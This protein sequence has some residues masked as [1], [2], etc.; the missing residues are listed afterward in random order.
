MA[1]GLSASG[2]DSPAQAMA[3]ASPRPGRLVRLSDGR[4]LNFRC[5]G[6]GGPTVILEAGFAASSRE[7]T[8]VQAL[9][10]RHRRVCA[11][12][13]AG[14]GLSD[15]GP[16]PR[17]GTAIARD[18]DQGL[19]A[20]G[21]NGPFILVGHSAGG[22]YVRVFAALRPAE[23][24]G[25]VLADPSVEHQD[26]RFSSVFGANAASLAPLRQRAERCL[27]AAEAH[28]LPSPDPALA[29]CAPTPKPGAPSAAG[30][31]QLAEALRPSTWQT[32]IS[33]LDNLW[34]PTSEEVATGLPNYG[35]I[36]IIVLTADGTYAIAPEWARDTLLTYWRALHREIA[37][38]S[39]RGEERLVSDSSHMM[40][41][42]RA[43]AIA[44]AIDEVAATPAEARPV[45]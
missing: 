31:E 10:A 45:Q 24:R 8:K 32:Q 5:S 40:M 15:P 36:P 13:R 38:K 44:D 29:P 16:E 28:T 34:T 33:E 43:D 18:L 25:M 37:A 9:A 39:S 41:F 21:I 11:Y 42:D 6:H 20:A 27:A 1:L 26:Q 22:L 19:K 14:Y 2:F 23:V 17:D 12:D 30:S 7:W 4:Q 3:D 35:A